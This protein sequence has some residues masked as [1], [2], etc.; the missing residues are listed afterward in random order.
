MLAYLN[1]RRLLFMFPFPTC[2]ASL[3][4]SLRHPSKST[5]VAN[6]PRYIT[7]VSHLV[8]TT[9]QAAALSAISNLLAQG[10]KAYREEVSLSLPLRFEVRATI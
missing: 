7:M 2:C 4:V 5:G 8:T 1:P 10:I 9:L 3:P 6:F